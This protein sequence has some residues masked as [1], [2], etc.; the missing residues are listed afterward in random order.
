MVVPLVR[1]SG[2]AA[3][4]GPA[5]LRRALRWLGG[6]GSKDFIFK[7]CPIKA[8]NNRLH[9]VR[10]WRLDKRE[11]LGFLRFVVPDNLNRIR[12]KIFRGEP[13]FNIVGGDPNG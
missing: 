5:S 3:V 7:R 8:A 13:L 1:C 6:I 11:S 2:R 12:Y 4:A 9:F 10:S